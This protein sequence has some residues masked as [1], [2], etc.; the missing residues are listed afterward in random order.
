M[1]LPQCGQDRDSDSILAEVKKS[2]LTSDSVKPAGD[3]PIFVSSEQS[4]SRV[5][6]MTTKAANGKDYT[7][8]FLLTG[9]TSHI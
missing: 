4:Y 2:F 6:A 9:E 7:I 5:A 3:A 1:I 8:L